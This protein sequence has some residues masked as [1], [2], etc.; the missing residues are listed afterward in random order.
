MKRFKIILE[1]IKKYNQESLTI[2]YKHQVKKTI[3]TLLSAYENISFVTILSQNFYSV[4]KW[5]AEGLSFLAN[6]EKGMIGFYQPKNKRLNIDF[7]KSFSEN[8]KSN[9]SSQSHS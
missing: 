7:K 2:A 6:V 8:F 4:K 9:F 3:H 5:T 1:Q